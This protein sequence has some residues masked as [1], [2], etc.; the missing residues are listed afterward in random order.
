LAIALVMD[1]SL[2]V[3]PPLVLDRSEPLDSLL[4]LQEFTDP[5]V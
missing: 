4:A 3:R 2:P 1:V 5:V